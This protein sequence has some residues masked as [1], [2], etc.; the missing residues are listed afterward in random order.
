MAREQLAMLEL[1][2]DMITGKTGAISKI[3]YFPQKEAYPTES[4]PEQQL[5][6]AAP[7]SQG[8]SS[9]LLC[10]LLKELASREDMDMHQFMLLRGGKVICESSFAPY[11]RGVWHISHSMCKSVTGMAVGLLISEDQ[12]RL[13]DRVIDVFG[14]RKNILGVLRQRD[15]TIRHLLTMTSNVSYNEPRIFA[16][17]EWTKSFLESSVHDTPGTVFEYNSMNSYM[18]SAVITEITGQTMMEYLRPRL[19]EPLG[20]TRVFWE[21]SPQNITKGGWGLFIRPEDAAKLGQLYL[22]M[23]M[24]NGRQIIPE[25]WVRESVKKQ[26]IIDKEDPEGRGY[27]YQIWEGLRE[28]GYNFNG[29]LGQNVIVYPDLKMVA[30]TNAAN[31]ELFQNGAMREI[32]ER[33]FCENF[34]PPEVLPENPAAYSRLKTLE[35]RLSEG[36]IH[37]PGIE[38]GGWKNRTG[39]NKMMPAARESM[40]ELDGRVYELEQQQTGLFPLMMQV[41]HN[42]FTDGIRRIGFRCADGRFYMNVWEGECRQEIEIGINQAVPV[43]IIEHEEPYL[44]AVKGEFAS[45]EERRLVLKIDIAY[46]EEAARRKLNIY[47]SKEKDKIEIRWDEIPGEHVILDGLDT[48]T[49]ELKGSFVLN[50]LKEAG[51]LE[52]LKMAVR[53]TVQPVTYGRQVTELQ[54]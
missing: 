29:M 24:W 3:E 39:R 6:R 26:V 28:G 13:D 35:K 1:L 42:N 4:G 48:V 9:D 27:G 52:M 49:D 12:L 10:S 33:Y 15:I 36:G 18:L 14:K 30:V 50:S 20:I 41:F 51:G 5:E 22:Q 21:S 16:G 43:T 38:R 34:C 7:E 37:I 32:I 53:N 17:N 47:W 19:W 25:D 8:I 44:T 31:R 11:Q 46:L 54:N 45:D 23:G 2:W 40:K